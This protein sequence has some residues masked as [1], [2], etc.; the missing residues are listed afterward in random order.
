MSV[1]YGILVMQ[2]GSGTLFWM[3]W[4]VIGIFFL[5]WTFILHKE[6]FDSHKEIKS[7]FYTRLFYIN[8]IFFAIF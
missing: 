6:F 7:I 4:E 2:V 5:I 1:F 8:N 3:I